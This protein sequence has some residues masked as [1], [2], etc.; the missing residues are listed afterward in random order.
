MNDLDPGPFGDATRHLPFD[1]LEKRFAALDAPRDAGRVAL[2][3]ARAEG[4]RRET[5][6][7]VEVTPD[8]GVPGDAWHRD[9]PDQHDCQITLMR[10]DVAE[11]VANGQPLTL[12]GDNLLVELDLS[13]ANLPIGSRLRIGTAL[14]EVTPKP[15]NGCLK[16]R[17]R[18]GADALRLTA[19]PRYRELR[20]RGIH[21]RV[22]EAGTIS[23]G[24]AIQVLERA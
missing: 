11:L 1:E 4:G 13:A 16:F 2:L 15:H 17:Q 24:D 18:F 7:Q 12:P 8:S 5:P 22:L 6:R 23:V 21:V 14:V 20:L 3:V 10:A 19:D 9:R